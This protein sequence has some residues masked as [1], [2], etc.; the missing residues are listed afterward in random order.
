[1]SQVAA[2]VLGCVFVVVGRWLYAHPDRLAPQWWLGA[3]SKSSNDLARFLGILFV[4]VGSASAGFSLFGAVLG[5]LG[6]VILALGCATAFTWFT[7]RKAKT[8]SEAR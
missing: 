7:F 8:G 5:G 2:F 4:F 6:E 1:M 3:K